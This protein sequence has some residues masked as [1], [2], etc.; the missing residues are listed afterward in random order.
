MNEQEL[1]TELLK[2]SPPIGVTA[3]TVAGVPLSEWVYIVTILYTV[4]QCAWFIYSKYKT[5]KRGM[6]D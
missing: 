2:A 6:E 3:T 5:L 4:L 1:K